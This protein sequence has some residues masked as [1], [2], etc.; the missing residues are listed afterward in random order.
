MLVTSAPHALTSRRTWDDTATEALC[1]SSC[2]TWHTIAHSCG[3]HD[4]MEMH[5]EHPGHD[6]GNMPG[7]S[8]ANGPGPWVA[9][10]G[11]LLSGALAVQSF[12]HGLHHLKMDSP[13]CKVDGVGHMAISAK[14]ALMTGVYMTGC[15][16]PPGGLAA[17]ATGLGVVGGAS[18][19]L[20]GASESTR[21]GATL[22]QRAAGL[23]KS[24]IGA[25][26]VCADLGIGHGA[27]HVAMLAGF[28]GLEVFG[29][30]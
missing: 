25:G 7:H 10:G 4:T 21:E 15:C 6:H 29:R 3:G 28:V 2:L 1:V 14:A 13:L 22:T 18:M 19:A 12:R 8:P 20:V 27:A 17:L 11:A 26:M 30:L 24:L 9:A 5:H 16:V 23:S